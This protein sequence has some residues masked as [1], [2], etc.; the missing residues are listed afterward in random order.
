MKLRRKAAARGVGSGEKRRKLRELAESVEAEKRGEGWTDG[1]NKYWKPR[2]RETQTVITNI[3]GGD[4]KTSQIFNWFPSL[5][6]L[7]S[8]CASFVFIVGIGGF[9]PRR[10]R[11]PPASSPFGRTFGLTLSF[12]HLISCRKLISNYAGYLGSQRRSKEERG[13]ISFC[14]ISSTWLS[15]LSPPALFIGRNGSSRAALSS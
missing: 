15:H 5:L 1:G 4:R 8:L 6:L 11:F 2:P 3:S 12:P 14:A 9:W 10:R 7:G 13:S